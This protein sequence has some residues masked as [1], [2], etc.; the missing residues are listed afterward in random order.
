[1]SPTEGIK[2]AEQLRE[3]GLEVERWAEQSRKLQTEA[4]ACSQEMTQ[5]K[6][7]RQ[8]NQEAINRFVGLRVCS[9]T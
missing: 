7:D 5:L 1:M 3:A 8:K 6:H 9:C 4:E 2:E